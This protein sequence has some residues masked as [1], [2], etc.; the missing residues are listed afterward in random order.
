M[1]FL[2]AYR[3]FQWDSEAF[4]KAHVYCVILGFSLSAWTGHK[5]IIDK[6]GK[7]E[8]SDINAYLFD[9]PYVYAESRAKPLCNVP[10]MIYG[11]KP[12]DGGFLIL[13]EQER[14]ELLACNP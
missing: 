10:S 6:D 7:H 3:T 8:V 14:V 4:A 5:Y 12:V 2:F 11:S 1:R 9:A 13:S